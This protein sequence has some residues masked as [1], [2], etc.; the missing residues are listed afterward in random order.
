MKQVVIM[1]GGKGARMRPYTNILPKPLLPIGLTSILDINL[2]QLAR[3]GIEEVVIAVGYLGELIEGVIGGGEKFGL[4]IRYVYEKGALG[5]AGALSLML[6]DLDEKFMV[7]NGDILHDVNF[8]GLRSTHVKTAAEVTITTYEKLHKVSLGVLESENGR[9]K[10]YVEKPT[11]VYDVSMGIYA[12]N[13]S[14]AE[15]FVRDV[16]YLDLP[17]LIN[18]LLGSDRVVSCYKHKGLW[19]D[20]GTH[21]EYLSVLED[22]DRIA[23]DHPDVPIVLS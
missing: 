14:V 11:K 22:L 21:A 5:T 3:C 18:I 15:E 9:L 23:V 17:S 13:R 19:V 8:E 4:K 1:A 2:R 10:S 20:L 7:M 12:M 16:E 6:R